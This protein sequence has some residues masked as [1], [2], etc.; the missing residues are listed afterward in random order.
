MSMLSMLKQT[1]RPVYAPEVGNG[2]PAPEATVKDIAIEARHARAHEFVEFMGDDIE[3]KIVETADAV[4]TVKRNPLVVMFMLQDKFNGQGNV[5]NLDD[6]PVPGSKTGDNADVYDVKV[7]NAAGEMKSAKGSFWKDVANDM[8][9]AKAVKLQLDAVNAKTGRWNV[10]ADETSATEFR[11]IQEKRKL[12]TR[13]TAIRSCVTKAA[14]LHFQFKALDACSGVKY[15]FA[16]DTVD[17]Q[18]VLAN[19]TSPVTVYDPAKPGT[20]EA[21]SVGQFLQLDPSEAATN[22]GTYSALI[23]TLGRD[24]GNGQG[25]TD[26]NKVKPIAGIDQFEMI[27]AEMAAFMDD[28]KN[29]AALAKS[30]SA[31]DSDDF[32]LTLGDLCTG[33]DVVWT[34][35]QDRYTNL[36]IAQEKADS[37]AKRDAA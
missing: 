30:L 22:G 8:D 32:V 26:K 2:T 6:Y 5:P 12:E 34:R 13:L 24:G 9:E 31:K 14:S 1:T 33:L 36:K 23:K 4:E 27:A 21:M 29:E 15:T 37:K 16:T 7:K 20:F 17:G 25:G 19:V 11:R 10:G 28:K 18:E 3:E 35:I